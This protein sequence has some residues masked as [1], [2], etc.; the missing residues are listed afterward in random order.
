MMHQQGTHWSVRPKSTRV[1]AYEIALEYVT[2]AA[3]LFRPVRKPGVDLDALAG[4]IQEEAAAA[5][6]ASWNEL[7]GVIASKSA[8]L[9]KAS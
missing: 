2:E 9:A 8:S 5:F 7:L 4:K 6:V 1:G 3:D